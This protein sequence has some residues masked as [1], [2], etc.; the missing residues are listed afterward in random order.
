MVGKDERADGGK[1]RNLPEPVEPEVDYRDVRV[2]YHFEVSVV[3][4]ATPR[5]A[6]KDGL[7][8]AGALDAVGDAAQSGGVAA[9]AE[10]D[11]DAGGVGG[12]VG[13]VPELLALVHVG[14]VDLD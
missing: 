13:V 11:D 8:G 3:R 14:E 1:G 9:E 6:V 10:A 2:D 12:D 4:N 7:G 5:R